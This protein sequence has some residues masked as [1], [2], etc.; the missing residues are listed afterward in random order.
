MKKQEKSQKLNK[1]SFPILP[2]A[3]LENL[4]RLLFTQVYGNDQCVE[5]PRY[6]HSGM[7]LYNITT[8]GFTLI[9][10][11]VVVLIICILAAVALPKYQLAVVKT[12]AASIMALMDG[13]A[14]AQELYYLANG[15]YAPN[16]KDLDLKYPSSCVHVDFSYDTNNNGEMIFCNNDFLIDIQSSTGELHANYC[17]EKNKSYSACSDARD[18]KLH[19]FLAHHA[20]KPNTRQCDVFHNSS[21]G[22]KICSSLVGTGFKCAGC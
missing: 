1:L 10:L 16:P 5:D 15:K 22:K 7:T 6:Q 20:S 17:P 2:S 12:R 4:Q 18:F 13:L 8:Q 14:K 3:G 11:L 19:Y 21:L 9:E